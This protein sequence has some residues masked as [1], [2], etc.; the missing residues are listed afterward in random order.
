MQYIKALIITL[1]RLI[2]QKKQQVM[3]SMVPLH[4]VKE[5]Q[6]NTIV[7]CILYQIMHILTRCSFMNNAN[8][9]IASL[10][11]SRQ[12]CIYYNSHL[13]MNPQMNETLQYIPNCISSSSYI[14]TLY[15][16]GCFTVSLRRSS[17]LNTQTHHTCA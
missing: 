13:Q 11:S 15:V 7:S 17:Y 16:N 3:A 1:T 4:P 14:V 6:G 2:L 12:L 9:L 5:R 8:I 10:S